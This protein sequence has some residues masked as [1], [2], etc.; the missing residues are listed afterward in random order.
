[1]FN[2]SRIETAFMGM[3]GLR[4]T[5]NPDFPQLSDDLIYTGTNILIQHPLLNIENIDMSSRNY[6][7]YNFAE[8][9]A[10][11][12]Y[13]S[14][15][16]V[17]SSGIVYESLVDA[18]TGNTPASSPTQWSEVNLLSL[19]LE[20]VFRDAI[21]DTVQQVFIRKKLNGQTKTLLQNLRLSQGAG[22]FNDLI[23]NEGAL[24]GV[25]FSLKYNQNIKAVIDRLGLQINTPQTGINFYLYHSSQ[26]APLRTIVINQTAASS[27]Q[28]HE[29]DVE[30]NFFNDLHDAG[31]VFYLMYDQNQLTGQ[32]LRKRHNWDKPPCRYCNYHDV[33]NFNLYSRYL[34]LRTVR[35]P[36][37]DRNTTNDIHM[38][39]L[40]KNVYEPDNNY[41]L[42]FAW[43]VRCDLT[44]YI[45]RNKDVFE[46]AVRDMTIQKLL[47]NMANSTRQNGLD[48]KTRLMARAEL[49]SEN[50]GGMGILKKT[51]KQLDA[52]DFE[53][54]AL[55]DTCMPCNTKGGIR[56][57]SAGLARGY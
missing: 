6:A 55:D 14:G 32:A 38:W 44:D 50:L 37:A 53:V 52:V 29:I 47:E 9:A 16:R 33:Q 10:G 27:L 26:L 19:Y 7:L 57:H 5:N 31:G 56:I 4:Q 2:R 13:A 36:Q 41:G 11:T 48:E 3:A 40:E 17:R 21:S 15:D 43:T 24:V 28:W 34:Y 22:A 25:E 23:I 8:W 42:N 1:M 18:N 30:I 49:Q 54:S 39:D 35:V 46:Y 45:I 12:T 51:Q 20:D